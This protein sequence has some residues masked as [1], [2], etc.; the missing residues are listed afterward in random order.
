MIHI[1]ILKPIIAASG[2]YDGIE[3]GLSNWTTW[4]EPNWSVYQSTLANVGTYSMAL[5]NPTYGYYAASKTTGLNVNNNC[6]VTF[7]WRYSTGYSNYAAYFT[8][9]DSSGTSIITLQ[10]IIGGM[11][12]YNGS[13]Y[14]YFYTSDV[15]NTWYRIKLDINLSTETYD[16]YVDNV[17]KKSGANFRNSGSSVGTLQ[18]TVGG[19]SANSGLIYIDEVSVV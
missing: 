16:I 18:F 4:G 15:A 11:K 1:P 3:N 17:L 2:F 5:R 7:D 13:S 10:W 12:W 8:I 14:S 9:V 19:G 6:I